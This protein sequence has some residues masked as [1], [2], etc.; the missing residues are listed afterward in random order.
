[1]PIPL[2][3]SYRNLLARRLTTFLTALG[4]ALVVFVFA[5][6]LMLSEGLRRTL[7]ATGPMTT[8]RCS[9]PGP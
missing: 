2:S 8:W 1:M 4:M 3:Y 5:A 7:A 9:G 6:V